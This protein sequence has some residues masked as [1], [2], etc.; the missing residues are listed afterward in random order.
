MAVSDKALLLNKVEGTLK[1]RMFANLM[2]EAM[3]EIQVHLDDFDV[4]NVSSEVVESDDLLKQF[5][6]AKKSNGRGEKTLVRYEYVIER[7]MRFTKVKT[8]DVTEAHVRE[9]FSTELERGIAKSTIEGIRE[10]LNSYFRWLAEDGLIKKNPLI[11]ISTIREDKKVKEAFSETDIERLRRSSNNLRDTAI[12]NVLLSTGCRVSEL[13]GMD[14]KDIDLANGECI[15][16]GKGRKERIVYLNEV[17]VMSIKEYLF[18]RNDNNPALF[19]NRNGKRILPGGVRVAL[20]R[21]EK[22]SGVENVHPHRFR[23]TEITNLLNRG[24]PI[25]EVAIVSGHDNI[26]TT[27][28]YYDSSKARIKNSWQRYTA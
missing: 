24:M 21:L 15:V 14:I 17:S 22:I 9:Y 6:D 28:K 8:R 10:T 7:F 12:I 18:T 20:K 19:V 13:V 11:H 3:E 1:T 16:F 4:T 23:R 5:I 27:M 2:E 25:Q 26:E